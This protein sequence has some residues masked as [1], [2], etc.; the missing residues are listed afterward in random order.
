MLPEFSPSALEVYFWEALAL[1]TV[2][3]IF[4]PVFRKLGFGSVLGYIIAG[5]VVQFTLTTR[6]SDHP[7]ELLHFAEFGVVLFL[8]VI[9]L[10]LKPSSLWAMRVD[11]FGLGLLQ[12]LLCGAVLGAIAYIAGQ[13]TR[14]A[15][16]IGLGLALS[17]TALVMRILDERRERTTAY[18]RKVF[19]ILLFQDLAIV[20][21]L[22]V[23]ALLAPTDNSVTLLDSLINVGWAVAAIAI[24]VI[25]GKFLLNTIFR[26]LAAAE[27][28]EIMTAAALGVVIFASL[29]L[30]YVGMSYAMGAFIAGVMLADS[31]YRHEIEANVE[32]FRGLF[33]ALFFVAVGMSVKLEVVLAN[34]QTILIAA[35][36]IL[37][38]KAIIIF[39]LA[40]LQGNPHN[41]SVRT[42]FALAQAGEFGF[43]LFG[44][45]TA[46]G[47]LD[48]RES[49]ALIAVITLTMALSPIFVQ[50][51]KFFQ[52]KSR[53]HEIEETFEDAGG[54][55]LIIGFGRFGQTVSQPLLAQGIDVTILDYD[56]DR[57][58]EATRFGFRIHYGNGLRRDVLRAAGAAKA[59]LIIVCVN[60]A[61]TATQIADM[62]ADNFSQAKLHVRSIDRRHSIELARRPVDYSI[63]ELFESALA[64]G[65]QSLIALGL[66]ERAA[67]HTIT[68]IRER[69]LARLQA[70]IDGDIQSGMDKLHTRPVSPEPL[71]PKA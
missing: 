55:A 9:G 60:T 31:D 21:L 22:L 14:T 43:V 17:S 29:L 61:S 25:L 26:S 34:W 68:E 58:Q 3:C 12:V 11:I 20:P 28:T 35:P 33:L 67:A 37:I 50:L 59:D 15:T 52:R 69:D 53:E 1:I 30:D 19:S 45:A 4:A 63:R 32:P 16:I 65:E 41:V 13:P 8:F 48:S 46:S 18:G 27:M 56:P 42:G 40:R 6:F 64:M 38:I 49:S 36:A 62:V 70:Q 7:E 10:E 44:A 51:E 23:A 24:L 54:R 2:A 57:I 47:L 66:E 39:V 71:T 5:I